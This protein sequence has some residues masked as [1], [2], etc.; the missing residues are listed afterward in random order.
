MVSWIAER[1]KEVRFSGIRRFHE[2]A[3]RQGIK[4]VK[5]LSIGEPDF[6]TPEHI[7]EA[8]KKALDEGYTHYTSNR[9]L[10]ELRELIAEKIWRENRIEADPNSEILITHGASQGLF[11]AFL[12]TINPGDEVLISDPYYPLYEN[13]IAMAGGKPVRFILHEERNFEADPDEIE[14][15]VTPRTKSIVLNSPN[16]PTGSVISRKSLE[17]ISEMT[18]KNNILV[19]SDE[20]YEKFVY[21]GLQHHSI[22]ALPEMKSRTITI[23]AFSKTYAMTGWRIGYVAASPEIIEQMLKMHV[24]SGICANAFVQKAAIAALEGPQN[25]VNKMVSEFK[26]R[27][28]LIVRKLNKISGISC[29]LPKG[30][31]YVFPNVSALGLPSEDIARFLVQEVGVIIVPGSAFGA[32]GEGH[33]RLSYAASRNNIETSMERV[34]QAVEGKLSKRI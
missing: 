31:F 34:K 4:D 7:K 27:R 20:V 10:S 22:A 12:A 6:D 15:L 14:K 18:I 29:Q 11:L 17:S 1:A 16:N 23:N 30:A 19:I 28:D 13:V 25:C 33:L 9:G 2:M 5:D 26:E 21:D 24:Y 8:A 32:H 3:M